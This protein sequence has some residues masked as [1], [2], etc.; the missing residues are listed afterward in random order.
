[1]AY[2]V[3]FSGWLYYDIDKRLMHANSATF[4]L[5]NK[6]KITDYGWILAELFTV[7]T[8]Y[9][10]TAKEVH[11]LYVDFAQNFDY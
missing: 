7:K 1:M 4:Y 8:R 11:W 3:D 10:L 6:P 2:N 5:E 9:N